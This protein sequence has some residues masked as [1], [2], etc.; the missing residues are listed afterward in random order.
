MKKISMKL[1]D[2][3]NMAAI[4][5]QI[6]NSFSDKGAEAAAA[7][8]AAIDEL[9]AAEVE[10]DVDQ[11]KAAIEEVIAQYGEVPAV[12][13]ESIAK[14]VQAIQD[15]MVKNDPK[16][17]L[18]PAIRNQ[19]SAAILRAN[20]REDVEDAFD[21][22]MTKNGI[23]GLTFSDVIDYAIVEK[24]GDYNPLFK[25][26]YRTMV[27][28]WFYNTDEL[29]TQKNILAKQWAKT[30]VNDKVI[31][32]LSVSGRTITPQYIYK[33]QQVA[34]EDLDQIER[35]GQTTNFLRWLL[36]ELDRQI[37]NTIVLHILIGDTVNDAADRISS[38][39]SIGAKTATD[40]FTTIQAP[41]G[42]NVTLS[43]VRTMCD[44]VYN[45]YG[46]KK[47]LVISQANLTAISAFLYASGG[48]TMYRTKEEIAGMVGVDEI[49]TSSLMDDSVAAGKI[50]A[51]CL[52]PQEYWYNELNS[53]EFTWPKNER[54]VI[55]YMRERNVGGKL[56]GLASSAVLRT[57]NAG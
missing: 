4:K 21:R 29:K 41:A 47:V 56:H 6:V 32:D 25:Q 51:V 17:K 23:S 38:F 19:V 2:S 8:R 31:Q 27:N 5:R 1:K 35:A 14:H 53:L 24:W 10:Y 33:M 43:D 11:F 16:S 7:V 50:N 44:K 3:A 39:E 55:N 26:F 46:Y 22:V 45:P 52:L 49:I 36:E 42:A 20:G 18:T 28:K 13:A 30:S 34:R 40:A 57:A 48:S 37:V 9:E 12:V 54:N 15:S